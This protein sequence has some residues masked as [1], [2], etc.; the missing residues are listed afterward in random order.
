MKLRPEN[1]LYALPM[2][3]QTMGELPHISEL[4]IEFI[5]IER[6][7]CSAKLPYQRRLAGNPKNGV[8]HGGV[9]TTLMDSVGGAAAFSV[10][11]LGQTVATLDLRIDYL[12]SAHPSDALFG[13][14]HCY[15]H[16]RSVVFVRGEAYDLD[17][18]QPI[19]HFVA[20]FAIGSIGFSLGRDTVDRE[21]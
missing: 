2:I 17:R 6:G 7:R 16:A 8:L 1:E 20:T 3:R 9:V 19:A 4:G 21:I 14:A 12:R 10:V 13:E 18:D 15:R 11:S 5:D